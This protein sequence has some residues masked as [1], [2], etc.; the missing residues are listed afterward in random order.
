MIDEILFDIERVDNSAIP[1]TIRATK[2]KDKSLDAGSWEV[3]INQPIGI[4]MRTS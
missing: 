4:I 2:Q 3:G 1:I